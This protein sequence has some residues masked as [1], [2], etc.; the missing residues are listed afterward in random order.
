MNAVPSSNEI[1]DAEVSIIGT[2]LRRPEAI[3]EVELDDRYFPNPDMRRIWRAMRE[4]YEQGEHVDPVTVAA[5]LEDQGEIEMVDV[6]QQ[7]VAES[8]ETPNVGAYAKILVQRGTT[9]QLWAAV[10]T[11]WKDKSEAELVRAVNEW[12]AAGS[13]GQRGMRE[14]DLADGWALHAERRAARE[15]AGHNIVLGLPKIDAVIGG[16]MPD[17]FIVIAGRPSMGKT[18]FG[19]HIALQNG[20]AGVKGGFISLEQGIDKIA[21]RFVARLSGCSVHQV[22][23]TEDTTAMERE[24]IDRAKQKLPR[25][26]LVI[27]DLTPLTWPKVASIARHMVQARGAK[28]ILIDYLQKIETPGKQDRRIEVG[29]IARGMKQLA[30]TMQ[31]PV[32]A[33][34]QL[35]RDS[36][37]RT[38]HIGDLYESAG[39]EQEADFIGLLHRERNPEKENDAA[40]Q[41]LVAKNR[42]GFVG[43]ID[44]AFEGRCLRFAPVE[45]RFDGGVRAQEDAPQDH[46]PY[47]E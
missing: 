21:V 17:D 15:A 3:A 7:L 14:G 5:R 27:N 6:L 30:R 11:A 44:I 37:G 34:A 19:I 16:V 9:A 31:V 39:I 40:A 45:R 13:P 23:G 26:P 43:R 22:R 38:P 29:D 42:E 28:Y 18:A 10:K 4:L 2:C 32:I 25:I 24:R 46:I 47:D 33:L 35:K 12:S 1:S 41:F 8:W 36:E 20:R